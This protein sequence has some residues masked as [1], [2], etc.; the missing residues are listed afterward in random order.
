MRESLLSWIGDADALRHLDRF[1]VREIPLALGY[2]RTRKDDLY[3]ALVG[4]LFD[5]MRLGDTS[6]ADWARLRNALAQYGAPDRTE[7][8][9]SV[10][11]SP[12][13]ATLFSAAA[14]YFGGFP[15]SAY[16]TIRS[17]PR[18]LLGDGEGACFDLLARPREIASP[19]LRDLRTALLEGNMDAIAGI[20][21]GVSDSVKAALQIGPDVWIPLRLL[22]R[23][24]ETFRATNLRAI[25]PEGASPFWTPLVKSLVNHGTWDFFPSQI[26][27]IERGLL[28]R[29]ETF[30]LQMPTGAGKTALCETLLFYHLSAQPDTA[31]VLLVPYRSLASE[32]RGTLVKR[33]NEMGISARCAYGGTV[34]SGDEVRDFDEMRALVA[35]PETLSGI[36]SANAAFARRISLVICD[37][38]HLLDAPSRGVGLE[39][40]LARMKVRVT[41][42]QRY[43]FVSAIVPNIEEI[44]L[45]LG[46]TED[47]VVRSDYRPAIAEFSVLRQVGQ[48][49]GSPLDLEMH[50]HEAEPIRYRIERFLR[51]E[52]FL[53]LNSSTG[54]INTFQFASFKT[55]A[56][57]AA[58]KALPMGAVVVFS[59]NKRG[60]QG[61]IGLT[62]ELL[63][64]I[65]RALPLPIPLLFAA[66]DAVD[67]VAEYVEQEY[68]A[69]WVGT[70]AI[71]A[72]AV[73]HHGDI[74]QETREVV[75]KLLQEGSIAFGICTS[76]LAEGVNL[77]IRTL[78]LYSVQ[79][80]GQ[81]GSRENL[82]TRD[83]KNLVGRAGR[84]GSTTKG[85]VICTNEDQWPLIEAV[86]QQEAGEPI[87]GALRRLIE[88]VRRELAASNMVLTNEILEAS[89]VVHSL[90]DGIDATIVE[91]AATEIEEVELVRLA[92]ELANETFASR[93]TDD[94]SRQLLREVFGLRARR[95]FAVRTAGRLDWIRETGTRARMVDVVETALLPLR[96]AWD[97][98]TD[99]MDPTFVNP[100]L[101]WAW[102][103]LELQEAIRNAYRTGPEADL[104]P[105]R[106]PFFTTV[107]LWLAGTNFVQLA[108]AAGLSVDEM[109]GVHTQAVAFALQTIVEQ[110]IALLEKILQS[111]GNSIAPVVLQFPEHLRF[112]V[113]SGV[114]RALASGGVRHRRAYVN[115]GGAAGMRGFPSDDRRNIFEAA[116]RLL[117]QDQSGWQGSLGVLV[118][119]NTR[120]DISAVTRRDF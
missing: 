117:A 82:L 78:V 67:A 1:A 89:P 45:W 60:D 52:D 50:P 32:L 109:L 48:A 107:R 73:L 6:P 28:L 24:L 56:I 86:A 71:K 15:A 64:Q 112:G 23:L 40:L 11:V 57:A 100:I 25:L 62:E 26:A 27:A 44:N 31:A 98:V 42:V 97:D 34:P 101:E 113:P 14:F 63:L 69:E 21:A 94:A 9:R 74:P 37:E 2:Q 36:L 58:R 22:E 87:V 115:L 102:S 55:R 81:E 93:Q 13:E 53:W 3:I 51:R 12:N 4:E 10:G 106:D 72:G 79:R 68:G 38:G 41:G 17:R 76:T 84:P 16:L 118:F 99:P 8:L 29:P 65:S 77:P 88:S 20:G 111:R 43:V 46:G 61:A 96:A 105:F 49:A 30:S 95:V 7:E 104:S 19:L 54:R 119:N 70:R 103:Q 83:I 108:N 39:L 35:T 85:L 59:A 91:L 114:G 47:S 116:Q 5:C 75:E 18:S 120:R 33:L 66:K 90:I 80:L 110:A 92:T